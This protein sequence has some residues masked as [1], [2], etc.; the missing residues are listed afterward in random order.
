MNF[1]DNVCDNCD[2]N[3]ESLDSIDMFDSVESTG[4]INDFIHDLDYEHFN[5]TSADFSGITT[6]VNDVYTDNTS[7]I[8]KNLKRIYPD[9]YSMMNDVDIR[10]SLMPYLSLGNNI[11]NINSV[12]IGHLNVR[13][14]LPK[15]HEVQFLYF[16]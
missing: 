8:I 9:V 5:D 4:C 11:N 6:D 7:H 13:S 16:R 14:L 3:S 12:T 10:Q 1:C 2:M 15:I